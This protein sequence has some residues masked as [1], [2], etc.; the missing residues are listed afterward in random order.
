M[1]SALI[2]K[3]KKATLDK[4]AVVNFKIY[5]VIDKTITKYIHCPIP[6]EVKATR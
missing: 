3:D 5:D 1:L 4:K 2:K 6:Q